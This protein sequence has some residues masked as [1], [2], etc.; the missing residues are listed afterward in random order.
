MR[1]LA[2]ILLLALP[3][4]AD[5]TRYIRTDCTSFNGDGTTSSC[6]ASN[7]GVGA[8]STCSNAESDIQ[9]DYSA[10]LVTAATGVVTL[11]A[12][13]AT[14]D[15]GCTFSGITTDASN[16]IRL[17]VDPANRHDGKWN[18]SKYR[19]SSSGTTINIQIAHLRIIGVQAETTG[20]GSGSYA[21]IG[22]FFNANGTSPTITDS[23]VKFGTCNTGGGGNCHGI[24][25]FPQSGTTYVTTV[26]NNVVFGS[27]TTSISDGIVVESR[28]SSDIIVYNNTVYRGRYG[29]SIG[30][31]SATSDRLYLRNNVVNG[32]GSGDFGVGN[33][34]DWSTYTTSNNVSSDA[35]S[36]D[37]SYR[38]LSCSFVSTTVASEDFHLQSGDTNCKNQGTDLSGDAQYSFSTD[39]DGQ[40]RTGTWDIGADEYQ[41]TTSYLP[42]LQAIGAIR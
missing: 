1:Y 33:S 25:L 28:N 22:N 27:A 7:G 12:A 39:I 16:Y 3:A 9:T 34:G 38:S 29:I 5:V 42:V 14:A 2:L 24:Y 40:T 36:P 37:V 21:A 6:A 31:V 4:F 32:T 11:D 13:G 41:S 26:V 30:N 20:S 10:N 35:S 15:G 23:V 8:Y 19:L 18:T 17:Y